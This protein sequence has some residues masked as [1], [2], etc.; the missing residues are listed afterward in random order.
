MDHKINSKKIVDLNKKSKLIKF[1]KLREYFHD[2]VAG[3]NI[4]KQDT[5]STNHKENTIK[6]DSI[7]I[8]KFCSLKDTTKSEKASQ[9]M[10]EGICNTHKGQSFIFR[11]RT[12]T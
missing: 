8:K 2:L 9:R 3:K 4:L 5:K 6:F 10:K 7:K 1:F 11:A 12:T